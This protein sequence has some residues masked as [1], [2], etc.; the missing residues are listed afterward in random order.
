[1]HF[2]LPYPKKRTLLVFAW[3]IVLC[4]LFLLPYLGSVNLFDS[5]EVN[6]A[7]SSREMILTGDYM[8]VQIDFQ[9]FPEKPPLF[10]WLQVVSMKIFGVNEFAARFPNFICSI[11]TLFILYS[12]GKRV[13]GH[14]FGLFWVLSFGSAILPL[15][16]FKSGI[17]DPWF[18]LLLFSGIAL[19]ILYM[20][21][22]R[23]GTRLL[24]V[25]FSALL[26]GLAVLTKGPLA[27]SVFFICLFIF[28]ILRRF[29]FKMTLAEG[30]L[31]SSVLLLVG[32][33]W[34]LYQL[35]IGN[36]YVL[37]E[38]FQYGWDIL[39]AKKRVHDGFFGYHLVILLLGVFPASVISMK[40]ITKKSEN[41]E[42][43]RVF[44][45]WMY[46]MIVVVIVI[47]SIAR[48]KLLNYSS[49]AYF[50]L[51]FL[52]AW[53]W[54]KWVERKTEISIWQV[55]LIFFIA[56][57]YSGLVVIIPL[58]ANNPDLFGR[59]GASII[60]EFNRAALQRNVH[61][62]G[63]EWMVGIFLI[64]GVIVSLVQI[65]RRNTKGMLILHI[66]VMLFVTASLYIFTGRIEEY[67]QRSAINFY[68]GLKGQKVYVKPLGYKSYSHL[69]YFD[70]QAGEERLTVEEMMENELDRDAYF[71]LQLDK[72][73]SILKRYP[74][75]EVISERYGYVFTIKRA[76]GTQY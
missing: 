32:G 14:R 30:A 10:F 64:I 3:I 70:K 54:D 65:L 22:K 76:K 17:I 62:S 24:N 31:F 2:R 50:P 23:K 42:L 6:Y 33:S 13:Y 44:K 18:N 69:Y 63:S 43:Q 47:Y 8:N 59:S 35:L 61:W 12:L 41:T 25:A 55:I 1:M 38:F 53:V 52:A 39:F 29:T 67:T 11:V 45:H 40:S 20:F 26:L 48:T 16:F 57:F 7:E 68:K 66:V 56:L 21:G 74:Q 75:L 72:K 51:T 58:L 49:L 73:E 60:D 19:F 9:P 46:I 37:S 15:F 71:V 5:N 36:A 28:L 34:Y 4:T 27:L